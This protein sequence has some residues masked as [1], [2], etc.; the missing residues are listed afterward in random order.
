MCLGT[1]IRFNVARTSSDVMNDELEYLANLCSGGADPAVGLPIGDDTPTAQ[2]HA[3]STNVEL[4]SMIA[5]AQVVNTKRF[6]SRSWELCQHARSAKQLKTITAIVE[7]KTQADSTKDLYLAVALFNNSGL[8]DYRKD[9]GGAKLNPSQM[10]AVVTHTA[11]TPPTTGRFHDTMRRKQNNCADSLATFCLVLQDRAMNRIFRPPDRSLDGLAKSNVSDRS[12]VLLRLVNYQLQFDSTTQWLQM[13][14]E[15]T[16]SSGK[17]VHGGRYL[18][19][20]MMQCAAAS[21]TAVTAD[22]ELRIKTEPD[23][24][25]GVVLEGTTSDHILVAVLMRCPIDFEDPRDLATISSKAD[26]VT[27]GF[28]LDRCSSNPVC[29]RWIAWKIEETGF[30]SSGGVEW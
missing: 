8:K 27:I 14:K 9:V 12:V 10:A 24:K 23:F 4:D 30:T 16:N 6:Q 28:C 3:S 21:T 7:A 15:D 20:V 29:V 13:K 11:C 26:S 5:L 19:H 17:R 25:K 18:Q 2:E 1:I 22:G